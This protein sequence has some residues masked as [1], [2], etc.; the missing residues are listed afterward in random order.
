[1]ALVPFRE[2]MRDAARRGYAVGYFEA[3]NLESTWAVADAAEKL[4]SP[5]LLG[6]SGI[7]LPHRDRAA[8]IPLGVYAAMGLETCRALRVPTCLV[9]NESPDWSWVNQAVRLGFG[10][11]MYSD[12]NAAR[13]LQIERTR[14]LVR[15][16]HAVGTA[17]EGEPASLAGVGGELRMLPQERD[18][19]DADTA[20]RFVEATGVDALAVNV[21]QAHLHGRAEVRLNLAR[22]ASLR[23]A[24]QVPLVLHGATSVHP[25]D[26]RA[27]IQI[28]VQKVN[29][30]S[31]LKRAFFEALRAACLES[32]E[33]YNPYHIVGSGLG[34]DVLERGRAAMMQ[35]VENWIKLLGS[36]GK[37]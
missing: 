15:T 1:M 28:G 16:A 11:V 19:T 10:L 18:M 12:E 14:D 34:G 8:R 4:N 24:V 6:F 9:F 5:V 2:L 7:Y 21:G 20:R 32:G 30:G 33:E 3:W 35:S 25:G 23:S 13:E 17:V 37:A 36:S 31:A 27:A 29:V 22:L 26:L